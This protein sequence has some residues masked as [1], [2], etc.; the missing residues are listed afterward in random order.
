MTNEEIFNYGRENKLTFLRSNNGSYVF[1]APDIKYR[2]ILSFS[3]KHQLVMVDDGVT[4]EDISK[5]LLILYME[6]FVRLKKLSDERKEILSI[7]NDKAKQKILLRNRK[8]DNI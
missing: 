1:F 6:K 5:D 4:R 7:F 2:L 8:L 3:D